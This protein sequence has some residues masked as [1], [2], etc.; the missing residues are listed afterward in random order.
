MWIFQEL[1]SV[2]DINRLSCNTCKGISETRTLLFE[3]ILDIPRTGRVETTTGSSDSMAEVDD[4]EDVEFTLAEAMDFMNQIDSMGGH[5]PATEPVDGTT[6]PRSVTLKDCFRSYS[7]PEEL[8]E[9]ACSSCNPVKGPAE[10]RHRLGGASEILTIVLKRFEYGNP[11][12]I[13]TPVDIPMELDLA[14]IPDSTALGNYRLVGMVDHHGPSMH[15][16][17]YT[18]LVRIGSQWFRGDDSSFSPVSLSPTTLR[19]SEAYVLIYE[20][21]DGNE[22]ED[23]TLIID[24]FVTSSSSA[25]RQQIPEA[26]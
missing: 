8:P 11:L 13:A 21:I 4:A 5:V 1:V 20:R 17:H 19:S 23:E 6:P 14:T 18:A 2:P 26:A 3:I 7:S 12:K 16:G 9:Y 25:T 24:Q 15:G 22:E 10:Q